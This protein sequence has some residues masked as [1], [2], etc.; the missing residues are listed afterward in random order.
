MEQS[1]QFIVF[2]RQMARKLR[3]AGFEQI[4]IA[5]N[6]KRP[7]HAVYLFDDTS[8]LRSAIASLSR[9]NHQNSSQD[10]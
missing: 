8:E 7:E 4:G 9:G 1:K 2:S 10:I 5:R 6:K 3:K